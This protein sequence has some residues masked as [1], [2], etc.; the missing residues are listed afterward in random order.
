LAAIE[1]LLITLPF[2]FPLIIGLGYDPVWFGIAV[3]MLIEI[4]MLTPPLGMNLFIILAVSEG[5]MSLGEVARSCIPFWF[6]LIAS[7]TLITIFP[8]IV[9]FL[10]N[11]V[12]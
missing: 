2:T 8:Q 5:R 7:L 11:L 12:F 4:G 10:P 1:M 3:V 9:L 6:I